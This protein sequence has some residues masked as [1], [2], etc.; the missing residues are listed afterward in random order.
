MKN[1]ITKSNNDRSGN[2]TEE[3]NLLVNHKTSYDSPTR[4]VDYSEEVSF[5]NVGGSKGNSNLY[6]SGRR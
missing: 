4:L 2:I 3:Y 5:A 1:Y 6:K